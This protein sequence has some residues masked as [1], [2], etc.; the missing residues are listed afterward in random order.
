ME[1]ISSSEHRFTQDLHGATSQKTAFLINSEFTHAYSGSNRVV[2][3]EELIIIVILIKELCGESALVL[4]LHT[5]DLRIS[6]ISAKNFLMALTKK[7][8]LT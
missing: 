6:V 4:I 3:P 5:K 1:A 8:K 2:I 7:L